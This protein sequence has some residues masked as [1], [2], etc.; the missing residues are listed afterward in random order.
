M[1]QI[2][3]YVNSKNE[4]CSFVIAK[5]ADFRKW[6]FENDYERDRFA[7]HNLNWLNYKYSGHNHL[8]VFFRMWF[9]HVIFAGAGYF[10]WAQKDWLFFIL[11][12]FAALFEYTVFSGIEKGRDYASECANNYILKYQ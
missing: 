12:L 11:F 1:G 4:E 6:A 2:I 7:Y 10:A 9:I 3:T 5:D 8:G